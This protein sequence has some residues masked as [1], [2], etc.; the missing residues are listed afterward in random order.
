[1]DE[2]ELLGIR[3]FAEYI[4]VKQ[5]ILRHYDDIGLF[6]PVYRRENGYR[7]YSPLQITAFNMVSVLCD[8][9]T[10]LREIGVLQRSRTP[11]TILEHLEKQ[12]ERFD[13]EMRR[14]QESYSISHMYRRMIKEAFSVDES[15][16]IEQHMPE[17]PIFIGPE[18]RFEGTTRF[19]S[20][21]IAFCRCAREKGINL[22]Y[23]VGAMFHNM[24]IFA[25]RPSMPNLFYSTDPRGAGKKEAGN[26]LVAYTRG[27]YGKVNNIAERIIEY[28]KKHNLCFEGPVYSL[29]LLDE[30]SVSDPDKYMARICVRVKKGKSTE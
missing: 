16:V 4:G 30:V 19:F 10:A 27:Y 2:T 1:M 26:Y 7:Y 15:A 13:A 5:S 3:E 6:C 23:P 21:F 24:N 17:T 20:D 29:Y 22:S 8:L 9:K 14:L 25:Q 28:A 12:E 11:E 18:T